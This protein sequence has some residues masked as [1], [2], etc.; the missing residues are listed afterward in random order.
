M[1][2]KRQQGKFSD[3]DMDLHV[4]FIVSLFMFVMFL[5]QDNCS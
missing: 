3:S 5:V 4:L 2:R 1:A